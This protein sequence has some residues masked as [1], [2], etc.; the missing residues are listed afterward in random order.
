M[1]PRLVFLYSLLLV[2]FSCRDA[3]QGPTLTGAAIQV[4]G[5]GGSGFVSID[6]YYPANSGPSILQAVDILGANGVEVD[7]Q[8][9]TDSVLVLYHDEGLASQTACAGCIAEQ[10]YAAIADCRFRSNIALNLG[11]DAHLWTLE[12]L[13]A[14]FSARPAPPWLHLDISIS[15]D[16]RADFSTFARQL[17]ALIREYEA[18][19]WVY[20][21]LSLLSQLEYIQ[22]LHAGLQLVWLGVVNEERLAIVEEKNFWGVVTVNESIDKALVEEAH[23]RGL[24]V[25]LYNVKIRQG[26]LEAI[27]KGPDLIETDNI[28]L[29]FNVLEE[30]D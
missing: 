27:A 11:K 5:H 18:E 22:S 9:T 21:E 4:V 14:N 23:R 10:P 15:A 19:S 17:V 25:I 13:L 28:P 16:C 3:E 30:R 12:E 24:G 7:V 20:V 29:L 26:A 1:R 2:T 6:N 8:M